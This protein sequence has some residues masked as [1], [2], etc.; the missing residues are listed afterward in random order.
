MK[1]RRQ[2]AINFFIVH[3]S[4]VAAKLIIELDGEIHLT[5]EQ[6]EYDLGRTFTLTELG[7]HELRFTNQQA[8]TSLDNVLA[9][10]A[11]SLKEN[12]PEQPSG[13]PSL[14]ERVPGVMFF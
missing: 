2:H 4:C 3:F 8:L 1:F 12:Y 10:I 13:S 14:L 7:Y 9:K 11:Q 6:A 5:P